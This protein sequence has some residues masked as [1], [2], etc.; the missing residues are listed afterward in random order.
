MRSISTMSLIVL[1]ITA[2]SDATTVSLPLNCTGDYVDYGDTWKVDIDMGV[3]FIDIDT[4]YMNWSGQ[5][6]AELVVPCGAPP[7]SPTTPLDGLF[8]GSLYE[9]EPREYLARAYVQAGDETSPEP[10]PF[11]MQSVFHGEIGPVDWSFLYD[12]QAKLEIFLVGIYRP[13]YLCTVEPGCGEIVSATLVIEGTI[14]E[15]VSISYLVFG[16]IV[17]CITKRRKPYTYLNE[18]MQK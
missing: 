13:D 17:I 2:Y 12:G 5:I 3:G 7:D 1:S 15:P 4:A 9:S 14:P 18:T 8:I 16:T 11:D 6:T 10:E